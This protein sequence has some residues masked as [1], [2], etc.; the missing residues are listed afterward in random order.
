MSLVHIFTLFSAMCQSFSVLD[1]EL[2]AHNQND[3]SPKAHTSDT[4]PVILSW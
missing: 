1:R 4:G 2:I 3:A